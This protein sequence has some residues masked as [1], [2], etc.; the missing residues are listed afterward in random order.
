MYYKYF[1]YYLL[2]LCLGD[3]VLN[4]TRGGGW[5]QAVNTRNHSVF[6]QLTESTP[7]CHPTRTTEKLWKGDNQCCIINST[8]AQVV[9]PLHNRRQ[10]RI[11][12]V[13][14]FSLY[15]SFR[16]SGFFSTMLKW[17]LLQNC[18]IGVKN[19]SKLWNTKSYLLTRSILFR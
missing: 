6:M 7:E 10:P 3:W 12:G 19:S 17:L 8:T 4:V 1:N 13:G 15:L 9:L 14:T 11:T 2:L 16:L 18:S 5:T